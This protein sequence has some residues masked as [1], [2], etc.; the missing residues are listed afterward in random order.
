[1][2]VFLTGGTGFIGQPLTKALLARGWDVT[3]LA[4]KP[5]SAQAVAITKMGATCVAGDVTERESMRAAMNG[6]FPA[7]LLESPAAPLCLVAGDHAFRNPCRR[8][9]G[10]HNLS[11]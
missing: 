8:R 10:W 4:R 3:V 9:C 11:C 7:Y 1:M 5:T 2:K 6:L